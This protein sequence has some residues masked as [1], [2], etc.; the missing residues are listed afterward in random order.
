MGINI[1]AKGPTG[2]RVCVTMDDVLF[3]YLDL[4]LFENISAKDFIKSG[5][6]D[7]S[8]KNIVDARNETY[9]KIV[10]PSLLTRFNDRQMDIEDIC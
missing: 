8:I 9:K 1:D 5:I 7:G 6:K 10:K 4:A 2:K 3:R